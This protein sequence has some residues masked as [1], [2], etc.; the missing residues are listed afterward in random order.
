MLNCVLYR[1]QESAFDGRYFP[2]QTCR[3]AGSPR[4]Y[5]ASGRRGRCQ[6][7]GVDGESLTQTLAAARSEVGAKMVRGAA[8]ARQIGSE[9]L[10][11]PDTCPGQPAVLCLGCSGRGRSVP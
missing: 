2:D 4:R 6:R 10:I 11:M 1:G 3:G 8:R 7:G 5:L 9:R